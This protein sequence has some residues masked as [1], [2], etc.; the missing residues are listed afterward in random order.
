MDADGRGALQPGRSLAQWLA[1]IRHSWVAAWREAALYCAE[2]D[3]AA[4]ERRL[5]VPAVTAPR[6]APKRRRRS[7]LGGLRVRRLRLRRLRRRDPGRV[8]DDVAALADP[9]ATPNR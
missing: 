7:A 3:E 4:E 2:L 1:Q 5:R 8:P 9:L 6:S